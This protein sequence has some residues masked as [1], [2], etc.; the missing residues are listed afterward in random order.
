M[1]GMMIANQVFR[2]RFAEV[3]TKACAKKKK[4]RDVSQKQ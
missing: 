3:A 2:G 1:K 4:K